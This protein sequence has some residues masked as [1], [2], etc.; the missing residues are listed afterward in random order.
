MVNPVW[1][2]RFL[3]IGTALVWIVYDFYTEWRW[4][5]YSTISV[6]LRDWGYDMPW[7]LV[8]FGALLWHFWGQ[9]PSPSD[10]PPS[11]PVS[12]LEK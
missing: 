10:I 6:V 5:N 8:V 4:G 1:V 7:L 2:T 11:S 3:I 9:A 12:I